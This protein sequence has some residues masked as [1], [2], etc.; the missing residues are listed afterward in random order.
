MRFQEFKTVLT[1]ASLEYGQIRK[2]YGNYVVGLADKIRGGKELMVD[3]AYH[4]KYGET[5]VVEPQEAERLVKTYFGNTLPDDHANMKVTGDRNLVVPPDEAAAKNI[6]L[7]LKGSNQTIG[8]GALYKSADLKG[9]KGFNTGDVAEGV[10]GA[11]VAA[12]FIKRGG[13]ITEKDIANV[14]KGFSSIEEVVNKKTGKKT[15]NKRG[16]MSAKAA[17]DQVIF[18]LVLNKTSFDALYESATKDKYAPEMKGLF[19]SGVK[20]ANE[21]DDVRN[22]I[23]QVVDDPNSNEVVVNSDGVADQTGTKADLFLNIDGTVINLLSL[24][25]GDVKQF[26]QAS[27]YSYE[28]MQEFFET[29]FGIN[30]SDSYIEQM[31]GSARE[32]FETIKLI[33]RD[34][35]NQIQSEIAGNTNQEVTFL[36]RLYNGIYYHATRNDPN[37][38]MVIMKATPN[39]PGFAKLTFGEELREAMEQFDLQIKMQENPPKIQIYGVPVGAEAKSLA[40]S[41]MLLQIRSNL[42]GD[43]AEGYVRNIVEM[44]GLLKKIAKVEQMVDDNPEEPAVPGSG[45]GTQVT[46]PKQ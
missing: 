41:D 23:S 24:K 28:K 25:A 30:I 29:T 22:A 19:L 9:G 31:Q 11:A 10:L 44:G 42:K 12:K 4:D 43:T 27:G 46:P 13:L 34:M 2:D 36:Q 18:T 14:I 5:V 33:Y 37:V 45:D 7:K 39:A 8:T 3:P 38:S 16:S 15:S 32:N 26:G 1:E 17:N 21:D 40:G 6:R 35:F 20:Y